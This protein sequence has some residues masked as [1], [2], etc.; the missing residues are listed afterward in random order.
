MNPLGI[1]I[2]MRLLVMLV[3]IMTPICLHAAT[4]SPTGLMVE[5]I[6]IGEDTIPTGK[7]QLIEV[8]VKNY[9]AKNQTVVVKLMMTMPNQLIMTFGKKRIIAKAKTDTRAL[10]VY[11]VGKRGA[12]GYFVAAR[13]FSTTGK[14][15]A[16]SME[17][18]K[19]RF[20]AA[21]A[22]HS[23]PA[24]TVSQDKPVTTQAVN[25][26]EQESIPT[27]PKK[28][29][30]DPPDL[31]IEEL[32]V[33][34]NNSILRGETAHIKLVVTNDGGDVA[35]NVE[36]FASWY[37]Q[38]RPKR[39][40]RFYEDK[41][42]IIAPGERKIMHLPLTIPEQEQKGKY[43]VEAVIDS[44]N[45]IKE[46]NEDNN[47]LTSKEF[48]NFS[49]IALEFPGE[50]HSFAEDGRFI[51]QW[52]SK[53]Y[54]QFKVQISADEQFLDTDSIFELPKGDKWESAKMIQPLEGEM[55]ALAISLMESNDINYLFWRV[56]AKNSQGET[57]VSTARKF[58]ISLTAKPK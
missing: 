40:I 51:F 41:I 49:D 4:D 35:E 16:S 20:F 34:N 19:M 37:Y 6:T 36:F 23:P 46:T 12:G 33:S 58:F 52:R 14:L 47:S 15:L 24:Q 32:S 13:V 9:S 44:S 2:K 11:P 21:D 26:K 18:Q 54:N 53:Q 45:Y 25:M 5:K 31:F 3:V 28:V 43:L 48:I 30:F 8:V 7:D 42:R 17:D 22:N 10:L 57:T 39:M 27:G 56:R 1:L 50:S 38:H 29:T 55:P